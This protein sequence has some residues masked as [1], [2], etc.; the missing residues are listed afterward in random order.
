VAVLQKFVDNSAPISTA[1]G[2]SAGGGGSDI[3]SAALSVELMLQLSFLFATDDEMRESY[4]SQ[5]G[6]EILG[7]LSR[8]ED[9]PPDRTLD[10]N[11]LLSIGHLKSRLQPKTA[12][13]TPTATISDKKHVMLSYAWGAN[14]ACVVALGQ[15]LRKLGLDVWRDEEGS[16]ILPAMC[17]AT[18]DAMAEAIEQSSAVIVCIS[19][20]Y[21]RSANC[22]MEG[23]W[24]FFSCFYYFFV[25]SKVV[26][27]L[28]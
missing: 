22:R 25:N 17:G 10:Q 11:T 28:I 12:V 26:V 8:M 6:H 9:M 14:K 7:T 3:E 20:A 19:P 21:K 27:C 1:D 5:C 16:S 18:D 23:K 4:F 13:V 24:L 15:Q 2:R